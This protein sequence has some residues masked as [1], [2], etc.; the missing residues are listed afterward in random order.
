MLELLCKRLGNRA[1]VSDFEGKLDK[2]YGTYYTLK[3][4]Q[5][6][7]FIMGADNFRGITKWINYPNIVID[8][9][10]III[11]RENI[12]IDGIIKSDEYLSKYRNNFIILDKFKEIDL[13]SSEYRKTKNPNLLLEEVVDFI[14]QNNLYKEI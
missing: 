1:K 3:H 7:Y 4:F 11:P 10:Y 2:Y 13:S 12:D 6:P 9:K 8:F 5:D 14:K